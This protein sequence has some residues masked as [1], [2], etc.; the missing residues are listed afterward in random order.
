[1][2]LTAVPVLPSTNLVGNTLRSVAA[3]LAASSRAPTA[4]ADSVPNAAMLAATIS[5]T[6]DVPAVVHSTASTCPLAVARCVVPMARGRR[7]SGSKPGTTRRLEIFLELAIRAL[8]T[9]IRKLEETEGFPLL[10]AARKKRLARMRTELT[11]LRATNAA[12]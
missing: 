6:V 7:Q 1:M 10:I 2:P 8:E 12:K 11:K 9:N 3:R 5:P 4:W